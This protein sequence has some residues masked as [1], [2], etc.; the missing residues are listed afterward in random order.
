[1][2]IIDAAMARR[3]YV[4]RVSKQSAE[5]L[6]IAAVAANDDMREELLDYAKRLALHARDMWLEIA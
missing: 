1:M 3:E 4:E 6:I 2:T 5:M